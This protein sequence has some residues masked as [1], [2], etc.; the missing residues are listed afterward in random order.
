MFSMAQ[1]SCLDLKNKKGK[2]KEKAEIYLSKSTDIKKKKQP[3]TN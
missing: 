2:K 3:K 1:I